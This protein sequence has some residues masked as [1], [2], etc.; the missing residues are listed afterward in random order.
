MPIRR[1][2]I[3]FLV[4]CVLLVGLGGGSTMGSP[5]LPDGVLVDI[6]T[7]DGWEDITAD[8]MTRSPIEIT[9]GIPDEGGVIADPTSC[10][11]ALL[12]SR[13]KINGVV[14]R[15]SD[16]NPVSDL[17]G[18]IGL[19]TPL[20]VVEAVADD[21]FDR[22][23]SGGWGTAPSG[24]T[25]TQVGGDPADVAVAGG[26]ATMVVDTAGSQRLMVLPVDEPD[27]EIVATISTGVV[28]AGGSIQAE[29]VF[30]YQDP[31]TYYEAAI[32]YSVTGEV[33]LFL[34]SHKDGVVLPL[35]SV[36]LLD[37]HDANTEFRLRAKISGYVPVIAAKAWQTSE[38]EPLAW[39]ARAADNSSNPITDPGGIGF[40][41]VTAGT[42]SNTPF[43][44]TMSDMEAV[45]HRC[46]GE[47][48][49]WPPRWDLSGQN[50]WMPIEASGI[51][52]RLGATTA[53]MSPLRR[54][55]PSFIFDEGRP[56][57]TISPDAYWPLED[58]AT[59]D[60]A[61]S[62]LPG[63]SPMRVSGTIQWGAITTIP[64][65]G[66]APDLARSTGKLVGTVPPPPAPTG[67]WT[68]TAAVESTPITPN[69]PILKWRVS[70]S[71]Y[72]LYEL[73]LND[74]GS[75]DLFAYGST[76]GAA[77]FLGNFPAS[78]TFEPMAVAVEGFD[79]L[80]DATYEIYVNGTSV[81]QTFAAGVAIGEL[82]EIELTA[83]P[84]SDSESVA[85]CHV[86]GWHTRS[87]T[88]QVLPAIASGVQGFTGETVKDRLERLM[89]EE[90]IPFAAAGPDDELL[91]PQGTAG[92]MELVEQAVQVGKG[93]LYELRDEVALAYL[94]LPARY[95]R[96]V[97]LAL[98]YT[99]AGHIAPGLEPLPDDLDV[100]NVLTVT[101]EG[102]SSA[103]YEKTTGRKS[104]N[105]PPAGIGRY[106]QTVTLKLA[107]DDQPIHHAAWTVHTATWDEDRY[108]QI[109]L[110][111]DA[112]A[113]HDQTA[114]VKAIK[115]LDVGDRITVSNPPPWVPPADID[116]QILA[117]AE[118]ITLD[119]FEVTPHTAPNG[120]YA[121]GLA[122][123]ATSPAA[124]LQTGPGTALAA[125]LSIGATASSVAIDGPLFTTDAAKL[126]AHPLQVVLGG[127]ICPVTAISGATSPQTLTLTRTVAKNHPAGTI[128]QV[129][130]P[131]T[132]AL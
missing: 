60:R 112:A 76:G 132:L 127:E 48:S 130:R 16:R 114:V 27:V 124:W 49:Q 123:D 2:W 131:F 29:V 103:T 18:K 122:G 82:T 73:Q 43:T 20:R 87:L 72:A 111:P 38:D 100:V 120:P 108:P 117:F 96:P 33:T 7:G 79:V 125:E 42:N 95:N 93:L 62:G 24:Q 9:R 44:M 12:N 50:V 64:G 61:G 35:Q 46:N 53:V 30:R 11:L 66:P 128:V 91:G 101:R 22:T 94:T 105:A 71:V 118:R 25:W 52:R 115:R 99:T 5:A 85:V 4:C 17:Y 119:R 104:T 47:V 69:F 41:G 67:D 84:E 65:S 78:G 10:K 109:P 59:T 70:G 51:L 56:L 77:F 39:Q 80:G 8:V 36:D 28:A 129:H 21:D 81:G 32:V 58:G 1:F 45:Q 37:S 23:V 15:Y 3:S 121:V 97:A 98:D 34:A 63:G 116:Q 68:V 90:G 54:A 31:G 55:M 102:G 83:R 40:R 75:L 13:S 26:S 113:V 92:L 74:D 126:A 19:N 14:G 89:R 6:W 106:P 86:A 88:F 107:T 110:D 57:E